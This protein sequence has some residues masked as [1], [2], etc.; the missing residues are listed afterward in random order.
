MSGRAQTVTLMVPLPWK[1][2]EVIS[3]PDRNPARRWWQLWKPS[4]V[5]RDY[6]ITGIAGNSLEVEAHP[7]P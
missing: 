7:Q 1:I 6:R 5:Y 4:W 2:G 3:V